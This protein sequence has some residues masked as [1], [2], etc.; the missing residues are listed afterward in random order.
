MT[1]TDQVIEGVHV[2]SDAKPTQVGAKAVLRTLS[3]LAATAARPR[4]VLLAIRCSGERNDRFL[5]GLIQGASR[6]AESC[7]AEL[8]GGDL[9]LAPGPFGLTVT[10]IGD[11][12]GRRRPVGRDRGRA[13]QALIATGPF[14]GSLAGR[15]LKPR[16]RLAEG[17]ALWKAGAT[18]L[19]DVSD[20]LARDLQRLASASELDAQ[21]EQVPIHAEARRAARTSGRSPREHALFDGEDHELIAALPRAA[22]LRWLEANP[23]GSLLGR[24]VTRA[25]EGRS[26]LRLTEPDGTWVALDDPGGYVHGAS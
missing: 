6:A 19:I 22:A 12:D 5:R 9:A 7:G 18:A 4:C 16:P 1:C 24:L 23:S 26:K 20:G 14:G 3:D 10:A 15:H 11:L 13:G 21:L 25:H 17:R 8:V 2:T